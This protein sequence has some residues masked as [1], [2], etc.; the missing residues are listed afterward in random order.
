MSAGPLPCVPPSSLRRKRKPW[1]PYQT[2]DLILQRAQARRTIERERMLHGAPTQEAADLYQR[3]RVEVRRRLKQD[4]MDRD[5][6]MAQEL[7]EA[8]LQGDTRRVYRLARQL[9]PYQLKPC[10]MIA[11]EDGLPAGSA[12]AARERWF[13]H[14]AHLLRAERV[15]LGVIAVRARKK[16]ECLFH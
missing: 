2:Y 11:D 12:Q 7:Y 3:L 5:G 1:V 4:R 8:H 14:F 6:H 10:R 9:R 16:E 15:P 13:R